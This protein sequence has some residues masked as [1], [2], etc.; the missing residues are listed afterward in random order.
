MTVSPSLFHQ[1]RTFVHDVVR[2]TPDGLGITVALMLL[3]GVLEGVGLLLL[4]P[5]AGLLLGSG[6]PGR[7]MTAQLFARIGVDTPIPRLA[8]LLAV[9]VL[10]M[11][12]RAI[13]LLLRDRRLAL[14]NTGFVE[15]H[16]MALIHALA[17]AH[18]QNV[19]NLRHA[20]V[21]A[22]LGTDVQKVAAATHYLL[23]IAVAAVMLIAQWLLTLLIAPAL[24]GF[25]V[26]SVAV[27]GLALIPALRQAG[28][29]G[30][31]ALEGQA[32]MLDASGQFLAGLKLAVAQNAQAAFVQNFAEGARAMSRQHLAFERRQSR[33]RVGTATVSAL[34]GAGVLLVGMWQAVPVAALLVAVV[35][36]ARMSAPASQIQQAAQQLAHLLPAYDGIAALVRD[37]GSAQ[38]VTER[39]GPAP[40][41]SIAFDRVSFR[42]ADG[43]GVEAVD[44][45]LHP[46]E[47]VGVVGPSGAGKTTFVDLLAGLLEPDAGHVSVGGVRLNRSN[48]AQY[49]ERMAYVGQDSFLIH[50]TIRRNLTLGRADAD[51]AVLWPVLD[52]VG[53]VPLVRGMAAGLD[54][55]VS[56]RG[57]RLS[58]G[59]RQRIALAR[60]LLRD[61]ALL[62]LDEATNAID[63]AGEH[64]ILAGITAESS[65]PIVVI[66]AH[67]AETLAPCDRLLRFADGRLVE[68]RGIDANAEPITVIMQPG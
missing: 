21:T 34:A 39:D 58:G 26:V 59:E 19:A 35:T 9:F 13:V 5:L 30:S 64:A 14:L 7:A 25:A 54:T 48:A 38:L 41:G 3:G 22:A 55:I 45:F 20:R 24:A 68:D 12:T 60:A 31:A 51:D 47:I 15:R 11:V 57:M 56:E 29:I 36:M 67:R 63:V 4:V 65:R 62:I 44:L 8:V 43:G 32:R 61:P 50:D 18:W 33:M 10:V 6:G 40:T 28:G 16:R 2:G 46:G 66:V 53:A 17:G 52:R 1:A 23:Q 37:L 49:R 42:H 27:G